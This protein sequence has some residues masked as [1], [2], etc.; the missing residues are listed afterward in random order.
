MRDDNIFSRDNSVKPELKGTDI[1]FDFQK[2][3]TSIILPSLSE[4]KKKISLCMIVKNEE[5]MIRN[6]LESVKSLVS[7]MIVVDT[8]SEDRTVEIAESLGA[9]VFHFKWQNDFGKARNF[10][11]GK[12]TG[13][14]I[15][16]MDADEVLDADSVWKIREILGK[17]EDKLPLSPKLINY[18]DAG[19]Q[20]TEHYHC[21]IFPNNGSFCYNGVI[22]EQLQ[23]RNGTSPVVTRVPDIIIH[24]Y[25]YGS[26]Y[27]KTREKGKRNLELLRKQ[28]KKERKNPFHY[29]NL[30]TAYYV[31]ENYEKALQCFQSVKKY[32]KRQK[33]NLPF[34]PISYIIASNTYLSME[35]FPEAIE[36]AEKALD[37]S[38]HFSD[39]HYLISACHHKLKNYMK[40]IESCK[41]ALK[42]K[43]DGAVLLSDKSTGGWKAYRLLGMIYF[44][45]ERW[46]DALESYL[47]VLEDMPGDVYVL[48][49][50]ARCYDRLGDT[51][52]AYKYYQSAVD[53]GGSGYQ[54]Y[55]LDMA[56]L[57]ERIK[58][59]D[60]ALA[61]LDRYRELLPDDNL[62][63]LARGEIYRRKGDWEKA[64]EIYNLVDKKEDEKIRNYKEL[65]YLNRGICYYY[66]GR[67]DEGEEDFR[68]VINLRPEEI[69]SYVNLGY[70]YLDRKKY[71][72]AAILFEKSRELDKENNQILLA[73]AEAKLLLG[74]E[75]AFN[76]LSEIPPVLKTE[77]I[78]GQFLKADYYMSRKDLGSAHST[79][80]SLI[81][82]YPDEFS[83][84]RYFVKVLIAQGNFTTA[85]SMFDCLLQLTPGDITVLYQKGRLLEFLKSYEEAETLY[86]RGLEIDPYNEELKK[87]LSRI[88][89]LPALIP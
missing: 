43:K 35:K 9:K 26:S 68:K 72:E 74:E 7:E 62:V 52:K 32:A 21:R 51:E 80:L 47:K 2:G 29:Y 60:R 16:V 53:K 34:L 46:D 3:E 18:D 19:K 17:V 82:L 6:C 88:S 41:N 50:A 85:L 56:Y 24:H 59:K 15:L 5:H 63:Q 11:L 22:H 38:P 70:I 44:D 36:A 13:D 57:V 10:S 83:V 84:Y 40:A 33:K 89:S 23:Y 39:A 12:A 69:Y 79:I 61:L 28:I 54:F 73:L 48:A 87:A 14:W 30:Q 8:G 31:E 42:S 55:I 4:E 20:M 76:L 65:L 25:G 49:G 58:G 77:Y 86:L 78:K 45:M 1:K 27:Y 64:L 66:L 75:D 67:P 37:Y 81:A 71:A